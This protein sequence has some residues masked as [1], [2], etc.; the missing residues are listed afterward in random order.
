MLNPIFAA[1]PAR[2][3]SRPDRAPFVTVAALVLITLAAFLGGQS[4]Q[5]NARPA[6]APQR[7]LEDWRG[8]S[9]HIPTTPG[10]AIPIH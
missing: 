7:V 6:P 5:D 2:P 3:L 4:A 8:N 9:A 1:P 10:Q